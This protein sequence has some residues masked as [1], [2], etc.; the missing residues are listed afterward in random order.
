MSIV[1]WIVLGLIAGYIGSRSMK[2]AGEAV[3]NVVLGIIGALAG[4]WLVEIVGHVRIAGFNLYSMFVAVIG[5]AALLLAYHGIKA[6]LTKE[7]RTD[8]N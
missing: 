1:G 7:S 5:S 8:R 3:T 6:D 2:G 4:G